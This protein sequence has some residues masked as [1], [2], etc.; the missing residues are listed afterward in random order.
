M[1]HKEDTPAPPPVD[2]AQAT[3]GK[4]QLNAALFLIGQ[5]LTLFGT[6]ITGYAISWYITL[7]TQ[8]GV[9]LMALT[10]A[11]MVPMAI[12]S[13]FGGVWADRYN[14]KY[15]I[16]I[17]DGSI[18]LVTLVMALFFSVGIEWM[19]LLIICMVFRGFGQGI[20]M[21]AVTALLAD[22]VPPE[23]L[24]RINGF[25]STI[26]S[27]S[28]FASPLIAAALL[29]F[30]PVQILMFVDVVTAAIGI[31]I[32]FLFV[33]THKGMRRKPAS[34][35]AFSNQGQG[36]LLEP[37]VVPGMPSAQDS[38]AAP[39]SSFF[40]EFKAGLSYMRTHR[41]VLVLIVISIVFSILAT[42]PAMLTPLQVTRDF[43]ADAWR[44][45]AI[46]VAFAV[47]M[48][49]G[50]VVIGI[51]GGFKNRIYTMAFAT[52]CFGLGSIGLG[53][54]G[55]FWVYLA[56]MCFV[57]VIMPLFNAPSMAILQARIDPDYMGRVF[58]VSMMAG[59]LAMPFGMLIFGP[60]ADSISID[61]LLIF[62]G[63]GIVLLAVLFITSPSLREAGRIPDGEALAQPGENQP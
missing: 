62:T 58:S 37:A 21:P 11:M 29:S 34:A 50:G 38:Q 41:F 23:Q 33:H 3:S 52:I 18:A 44:L 63:I 60:L 35:P 59:S 32:V 46:E 51:W 15:L 5:A 27:L 55:N 28:M 19:G 4:W 30:F 40:S 42:P 10:V 17:V 45:G 54:L 48:M 2:H 56:C 24:V 57:G 31:T 61:L 26:Q 7:Q 12:A 13:P 9:M 22:I 20:Q 25:N 49:V 1:T 53:L 36:A 14:R 39:Q 16:N 6:M 8:S 43:G 47:G